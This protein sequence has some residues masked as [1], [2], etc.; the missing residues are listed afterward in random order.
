MSRPSKASPA[1]I[2]SH[3]S[4]EERQ[5][6]V[7]YV[8]PQRKEMWGLHVTGLRMPLFP[9]VQ[10][11]RWSARSPFG[12]RHVTGWMAVVRRTEE[13]TAAHAAHG[14]GAGV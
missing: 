8:N 14:Q 3:C 7:R 11:V 6:G 9:T 10:P 13:H 4:G 5:C 2:R 1:D 12:N